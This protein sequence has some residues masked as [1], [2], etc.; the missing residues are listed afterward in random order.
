MN[1]LFVGLG[2]IAKKHLAAIR[3]LIVEPYIFALRSDCNSSS[4]PGI[5]NIYSLDELE[6]QPDFIIISNP[7]HL[8]AS[9]IKNALTLN[10]PL[11]IEKPVL[12]NL[13]DI[14]I[15]TESIQNKNILTYVACNLRFHPVIQYLYRYLRESTES[16]NEVNIY[17]GSFLPDW[18]PERNF[19]TIY[20][21]KTEMG[22]GVHLD[23][24]HEL[25]YCFWLFGK[26]IEVRSLKRNV[27]TLHIDAVDFA[28]YNFLYKSFSAN[29]VLNYYRKDTRR[30]IE[31]VF[32]NG[33]IKADLI[34]CLVNNEITKR[35][36]YQ[37]E[38][39]IQ[40]TYRIQMKYFI[41]KIKL[42]QKPMN[43]F[44]EAVETLKM[45]LT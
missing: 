34:Q 28:Q 5:K 1:I 11:F 3:D 24:I 36:M 41:D 37:K 8:H 2:S 32:E 31:I 40:D 29:I 30:D 23:L 22:G 18:R 19:K 45:V 38:F 44:F 13:K 16:I 10:C 42:H 35:I 14:E 12:Q 26:P 9:T 39:A 20:S 4:L 21:S 25:D 15:L 33:T 6:I 7:T 17:C 27:S 43:D